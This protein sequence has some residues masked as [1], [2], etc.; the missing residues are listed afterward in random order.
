MCL[1]PEKRHKKWWPA[2]PPKPRRRRNPDTDKGVREHRRRSR[3]AQRNRRKDRTPGFARDETTNE[4]RRQTPVCQDFLKFGG[5]A[6]RKKGT[7]NGG[8]FISKLNGYLNFG[9]KCK[10]CSVDTTSRAQV[11]VPP[12]RRL[13]P[14]KIHSLK[15][16]PRIVGVVHHRRIIKNGIHFLTQLRLCAIFWKIDCENTLIK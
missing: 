12:D 13:L 15:F 11:A 4:K 14:S 1:F 9:H 8:G 5:D 7:K 6:A 2:C 10:N 16:V 3:G